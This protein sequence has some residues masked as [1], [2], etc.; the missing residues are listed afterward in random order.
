MGDTSGFA[1]VQRGEQ[2]VRTRCILDEMA[3]VFV[4]EAL[5]APLGVLYL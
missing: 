2:P 3:T 1:G 5:S 4:L